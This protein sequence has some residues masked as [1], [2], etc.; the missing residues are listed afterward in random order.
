VTARPADLQVTSVIVSPEGL[1][2]GDDFTVEWTVE[3]FGFEVWHGTNYWYDAVYLSTDPNLTL[4]NSNSVTGGWFEWLGAFVH[5]HDPQLGPGDSYTN[6]EQFT[7]PRGI[8]G[9]YY[10]YVFTNVGGRDVISGYS[11]SNS[12]SLQFFRSHVLEDISNNLGSAAFDVTYSEP[13][14]QVTSLTLPAGQPYSGQNISLSWSVEN[15]GTRAA[16]KGLGGPA[17]RIEVMGRP[18][19]PVKRSFA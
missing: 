9:P 19:V 5:P 14:L 4:D 16:K 17:G 10:A 7:L 2:S 3:N 12:S 13:D 1:Y 6:S 11:S 15:F 8:D 18:C